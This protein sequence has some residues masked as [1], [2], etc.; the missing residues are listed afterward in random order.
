MFDRQSGKKSWNIKSLFSIEN[1]YSFLESFAEHKLGRFILG[2]MGGMF[3]AAIYWVYAFFFYVDVSLT[4]GI[5]GSLVLM[6]FCAIAA[7]FGNF[8]QFIEDLKL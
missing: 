8:S 7:T 2:G 1:L 6:F 5:I 4:K 3:F